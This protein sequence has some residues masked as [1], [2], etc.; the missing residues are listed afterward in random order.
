M[1]A[2]FQFN[3]QIECYVPAAKRQY[4]YFSL[5]LLYRGEFIGRM[6]CKAHRKTRHLEIK[7]L[8]VEQHL[9]EQHGF[10]EN[11]VIAAFLK[12]IRQFRDFQQCDS[13]SLTQAQPKKLGQGLGDVL[14]FVG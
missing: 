7:L 10:E 4:G 9:F 2:L 1:N 5:P 8:Q 12:A 13:I 6:D 14:N 11:L 3:Y